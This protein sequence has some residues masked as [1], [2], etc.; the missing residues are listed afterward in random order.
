MSVEIQQDCKVTWKGWFFLVILL[1]SLSGVCA[2]LDGPLRALDFQVLSGNFGEVAKG[3]NFTG[4]GGSGARDGFMFALTLFPTLMFALGFIQVAESMGALRAAEKVFRPVLRPF[5]GIPGVS[6]LAFV[7]SFTSSDVGAV[8]TK[9]LVEDK[10]MA[11]NE[12]TI[13]VAYQYAGSAPVANTFG[14]GAALLP[15]S[16]LPVG[17]VILLI[18]IVKV[19]GANL[20]RMYLV[21]YANKQGGTA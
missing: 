20:V 7:S 14:S 3:V 21:W 17:V 16:V 11:D 10:L 12:R 5:M 1:I 9:G 8:M 2:K 6:G 4:K 13:F 18:F 19:M 15:I